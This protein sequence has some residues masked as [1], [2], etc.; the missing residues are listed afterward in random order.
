MASISISASMLRLAQNLGVSISEKRKARRDTRRQR[1]HALL[2]AH[3]SFAVAGGYY[4]VRE[5][6]RI[7]F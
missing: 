7:F 5:I 3:L 2:E 1:L 6:D 4:R